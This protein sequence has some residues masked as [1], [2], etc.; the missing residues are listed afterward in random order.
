MSAPI[1]PPRSCGFTTS[2]PVP[3]YWAAYGPAGAPTLLVLHGGPGAHHDYMLPQMLEL[4]SDYALI[5]YD[6]R[7]GGRS[8]TSERSPITWRTHVGDLSL[9]VRELGLTPLS[10]LGFSWGGLLALLYAVVTSATAG[11]D[12]DDAGAPPPSRMVLLDPASA[13]GDLRSQF[14][15][16]FAR[17]QQSAEVQAMRA[18]LAASGLRE[19]DHDA[20]RQRLFELSVAGYFAEPQRARELTPFR[21]TGRVQQSVWES[22]DGFDLTRQLRAVR[23]PTLIV[24]GEADPIPVASSQAIAQAMPNAKLVTLPGSGHVPYV[25]AADALFP[26]I[27]AFLAETDHLVRKE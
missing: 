7:G 23:A 9:L 4:A 6:Q 8:V 22:L 27:R 3:L 14:E 20:Y 26:A 12:D 21:V 19:R 24:H 15:Q 5:F 25:E 13:A 18:E 17:R 2:T 1:P 11:D 16:E 10:L